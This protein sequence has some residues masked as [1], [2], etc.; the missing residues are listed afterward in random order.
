MELIKY[1]IEESEHLFLHRYLLVYLKYECKFTKAIIVRQDVGGK[2]NGKLTRKSK[3]MSVY[4]ASLAHGQ[5]MQSRDCK[6]I[7]KLTILQ[8]ILR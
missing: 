5:C 1:D 6:G 2:C 3:S 7:P 8:L 4:C